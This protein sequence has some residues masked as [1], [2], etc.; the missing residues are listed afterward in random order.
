MFFKF[1]LN[2][3]Y[4]QIYIKIAIV[5]QCVLYEKLSEEC[6]VKI[7]R[8]TYFYTYHYYII[9]HKNYSKKHQEDELWKSKATRFSYLAQGLFPGIRKN[10]TPK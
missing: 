2:I 10:S 6:L 1:F 3:L 9:K 8:D 7:Y 5:I 4:N